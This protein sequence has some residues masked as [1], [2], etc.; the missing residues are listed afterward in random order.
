MWKKMNLFLKTFMD[1]CMLMMEVQKIVLRCSMSFCDIE[2]VLPTHLTWLRFCKECSIME[3][4]KQVN[5]CC[6]S[7]R[8]DCPLV[9]DEIHITMQ[10]CRSQ[11]IQF[12]NLMSYMTK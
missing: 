3:Q 5:C 9:Q 6:S 8:R 7:S 12:Q 2:D 11:K 10:W 4:S 1:C